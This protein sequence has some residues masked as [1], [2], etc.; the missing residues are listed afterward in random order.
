[1]NK[2]VVCRP[3]DGITINAEVEFLLNDEGTVQ[4]FGSHE[5]SKEFLRK[6]G[7]TDEEMEHMM[8]L[9]S[10]GV[11]K[12]CG[13]PLFPSLLMEQGYKYPCFICDEDFYSF[14]Q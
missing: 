14:E 9:E 6:H 12:R 3:V 8:F 4:I 13:S 11:C 5:V 1:M 10:C 2:V 7:I